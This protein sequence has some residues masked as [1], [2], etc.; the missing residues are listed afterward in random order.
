MLI[1]LLLTLVYL[2]S[3][4]MCLVCLSPEKKFIKKFQKGAK[5]I[6]KIQNKGLN[7]GKSGEKG[8]KRLDKR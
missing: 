1:P 7:V 4:R 3:R 6:D 8:S 5:S 2:G